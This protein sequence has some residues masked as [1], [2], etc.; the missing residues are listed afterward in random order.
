MQRLCTVTC[1]V[2]VPLVSLNPLATSLDRPCTTLRGANASS[3]YDD[4]GRSH[5]PA[6]ESSCRQC[7]NNQSPHLRN[8]CNLARRSCSWWP[9][10]AEQ[11]ARIEAAGSSTAASERM[12]KRVYAARQIENQT[13][14]SPSQAPSYSFEAT[15]VRLRA[16]SSAQERVASATSIEARVEPEQREEPEQRLIEGH[17]DLSVREHQDLSVREHQ[18]L[19]VRKHQD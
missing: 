17:Q 7:S 10:A 11:S 5:S 3:A 19:S 14:R 6:C 4:S 13:S 18:D 2:E 12:L 8:G 1:S 16:P 9:P 15:T